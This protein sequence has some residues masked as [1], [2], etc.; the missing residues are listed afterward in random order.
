MNTLIIAGLTVGVLLMFSRKT[1]NE[2]NTAEVYEITKKVYEAIEKHAP[3]YGVSINF[4]KRLFEIEAG[5]GNLKTNGIHRRVLQGYRKPDDVIGSRSED[6][7]S[8]GVFQLRPEVAADRDTSLF[9]GSKN[10]SVFYQQFL[11]AKDKRPFIETVKKLNNIDYSTRLACLHIKWVQLYLKNNGVA[12]TEETV[13]KSYN[14]GAPYTVLVVKQ[15]RP[16]R[17]AGYWQKFL[18]VKV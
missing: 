8:F 5:D 17:A 18:N 9:V 4:M 3:I 7:L 1:A 6:E 16:D 14:Q 15:N 2:I 13:A 11:T 10:G 12:I